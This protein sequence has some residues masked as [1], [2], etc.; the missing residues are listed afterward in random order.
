M[1]F[2]ESFANFKNVLNNF[3]I[4]VTASQWRLSDSR[5]SRLLAW[6]RL[7]V[8]ATEWLD[9]VIRVQ[10]PVISTSALAHSSSCRAATSTV[11]YREITDIEQLTD[12]EHVMYAAPCCDAARYLGH[13]S[14]GITSIF[15]AAAAA[16]VE[17]DLYLH[18]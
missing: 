11:T 10:S 8:D 9:A 6:Q 17:S 15:T 2:G 1:L 12:N 13:A 18:V 7:S 14:A 16:D 4:F 5:V 3:C